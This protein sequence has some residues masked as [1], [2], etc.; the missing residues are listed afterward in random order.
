MVKGIRKAFCA[1]MALTL[2]AG[3]LAGCSKVKTV[4]P[5]RCGTT[6]KVA[7]VT[8]K[9]EETAAAGGFRSVKEDYGGQLPENGKCGNV[10]FKI[11]NDLPATRRNS[12]KR[13]YFIDTLEQENSPYFIFICSG[14]RST[15]GYGIKIVDLGIQ[16]G[17]FVVICEET[18]PAPTDM[19]TEALTYPYC[20]LTL[21]H[22]PSKI[23]ITDKGGTEF[24][25]LQAA[26]PAPQE[27]AGSEETGNTRPA[28]PSTDP[29]TLEKDYKIPEGWIAA[30]KNGSGEMMRETYV[31]KD[32]SGYKYINVVSHTKSWGS[33]VWVNQFKSEGIC[34][35]K[36]EVLE[37]AG[38]FGSAGFMLLPGNSAKAYD[39]NT[40]LK[41][42][43]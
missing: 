4:D 12:E 20:Q 24:P 34:K 9:T 29:R 25:D 16:D 13:G 5:E 10:E 27:T 8:E 37:A 21:D 6:L 36:E 43:L 39:I 17:V 22:M 23:R 40:F 26:D 35:S 31:Y 2:M 38:N 41:K 3:S 28:D 15:G 19:V 1:V 30:F 18:S 14:M 42:D 7:L 11:S 32:N 33:P